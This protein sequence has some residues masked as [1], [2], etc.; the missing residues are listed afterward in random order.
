MTLLKGTLGN[1]PLRRAKH[2]TIYLLLHITIFLH[3]SQH[4]AWENHG[5]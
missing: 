1:F 2:I 3:L 4:C 5:E